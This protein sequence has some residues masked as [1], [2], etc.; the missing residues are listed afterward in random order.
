MANT[1]YQSPVIANPN[2]ALKRIAVYDALATLIQHIKAGTGGYT[3]DLVTVDFNVTTPNRVT[4]TLTDPLP[5]QTQIDR[6][7]LTLTA[8][9]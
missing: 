7:N 2:V 4:I 6:Y 8:G 3:M 5:N 1:T 9:G